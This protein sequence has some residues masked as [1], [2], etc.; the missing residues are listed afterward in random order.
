MDN[1]KAEIYQNYI[2][3]VYKMLIFVVRLYDIL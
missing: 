1:E 2:N 3:K